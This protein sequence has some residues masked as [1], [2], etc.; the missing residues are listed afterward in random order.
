MQFRLLKKD[1]IDVVITALRDG[2]TDSD[3]LDILVRYGV[4]DTA[5][6]LLDH[7]E[8]LRDAVVP[9]ISQYQDAIARD[10]QAAVKAYE[11]ACR[12]ARRRFPSPGDLAMTL[13]EVQDEQVRLLEKDTRHFIYYRPDGSKRYTPEKQQSFSAWYQKLKTVENP[14]QSVL[15]KI[16]RI[17][18]VDTWIS[19]VL[20]YHYQKDAE[21][22]AATTREEA[23]AVIWDFS[24]F[25]AS[26][27]DVRLREI[28]S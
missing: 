6:W 20:A 7:A 18:E 13:E 14:D 11:D 24:Q 5:S 27:P 10:D 19:Q 16:A 3:V 2:A 23:L 9:P 12:A 28:V 22:R 15:D 25:E 8:D 4:E 1:P 26:D 17:E 21:I